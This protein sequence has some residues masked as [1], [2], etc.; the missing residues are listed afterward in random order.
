MKSCLKL[1][2]GLGLMV[3]FWI[4]AAESAPTNQRLQGA[5]RISLNEAQTIELLNQLSSG[6][7]ENVP[8]DF[9]GDMY[10][11]ELPDVVVFVDQTKRGNSTGM[12]PDSAV[13][14]S[15]VKS[16]KE[17]GE[18]FGERYI[19]ALVFVAKSSEDSC[20]CADSGKEPI[21]VLSRLEQR[22]GSGEFALISA[23]KA[24]AGAFAQLSVE[25]REPTNGEAPCSVG[26]ELKEIGKTDSTLLCHGRA[27][28][29]LLV[30]TINR[31][32][33]EDLD[34]TAEPQATFGN[35]SKSWVTS[36]VG[37]VGFCLGSETARQ[38]K[39][40]R[41]LVEP[42]LFGHIYLK[43]PQRPKP[44]LN[45]IRAEFSGQ[46]SY[47]LVAGTSLSSDLLDDLF[48]GLSVGHFLSTMGV[49][50][51]VNY[52]TEE[53]PDTGEKKR[54]GHFALGVTFIF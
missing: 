14:V 35:Y 2:S 10:D 45:S 3:L 42:F 4:C 36:S 38:E 17:R 26:L 19:Y 6:H 51:G 21:V 33:V 48:F 30:N 16:K 12:L 39:A 11:D 8:G 22:P 46:I 20:S 41:T 49:V 44:R 7:L 25:G 32:R 43:R 29:P 52:R 34:T 31:L 54:K 50:A 37:L 47:S 40:N 15:L 18:L 1:L 5:V 9:Y 27:K 24:V 28:L 53:S 13:R 23:V